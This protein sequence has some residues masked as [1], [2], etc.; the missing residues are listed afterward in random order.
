MISNST[1]TWNDAYEGSYAGGVDDLVRADE[2]G[3]IFT[4][5]ICPV[6]L[7]SSLFFFFVD[8]RVSHGV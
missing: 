5:P 6:H 3:Q 8:S 2:I 1:G 4:H 7:S